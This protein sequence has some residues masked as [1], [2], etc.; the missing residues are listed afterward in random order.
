MNENP[1][2]T[3]G[4]PARLP[5]NCRNDRLISS[6]IFYDQKAESAHSIYNALKVIQI[7]A[8]A[9]IPIAAVLLKGP[10]SVKGTTAALGAAVTAIE[11]YIQFS[12]CQ[13]NWI[14]WRGASEAL[15][16]EAFLFDGG[17]PPYSLAIVDRAELLTENVEAIVAAEQQ[18][19]K[20]TAAKPPTK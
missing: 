5:K 8:G 9:L 15:A 3:Q 1:S 14:R 13:Q 6:F 11:S 7:I 18:T 19:W 17:V 2:P 12:Q 20:T 10:D 4:V 16:R